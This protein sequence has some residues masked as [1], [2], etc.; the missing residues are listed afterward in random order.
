ML[1]Q[2]L[3]RVEDRFKLV[4]LSSHSPVSCPHFARA[5]P[6]MLRTQA[7]CDVEEVGQAGYG[8]GLRSWVQQESN[9]GDFFAER[10]C[11]F[12]LELCQLRPLSESSIERLIRGTLE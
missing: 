8:R 7:I 4:S 9:F 11:H 10:R 6:A 1:A 3:M 2:L 12:C 5:L